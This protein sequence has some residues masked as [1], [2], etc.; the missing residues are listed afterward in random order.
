M[1]T[2]QFKSKG[3]MRP[4]TLQFAQFVRARRLAIGLT[5]WAMEKLNPK[6]TRGFISRIESGLALPTMTDAFME[7]YM[8][9]LNLITD[10]DRIEFRALAYAAAGRIPPEI[11]MDPSGAEQIVADMK[12]IMRLVHHE[13]GD[14]DREEADH[15]AESN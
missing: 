8:D 5:G 6:L 3:R 1:E 7:P 11:S 15:E 9:A 13:H 10:E 4:R 12:H 2:L 14:R